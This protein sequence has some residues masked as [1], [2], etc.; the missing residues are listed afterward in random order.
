M[1]IELDVCE[2]NRVNELVDCLVFV[3]VAPGSCNEANV[4]FQRSEG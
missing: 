1:G 2:R 4:R 3:L